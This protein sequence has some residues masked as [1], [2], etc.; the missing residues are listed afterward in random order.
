M[1][2][3]LDIEEGKEKPVINFLKQ[4]D[5]LTIK[6]IGKSVKKK[7]DSRITDTGDLPYFDTCPDWNMDV[8]EMRKKD[9]NRR[10]EGWL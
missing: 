2:Y 4:L 8:K 5:F 3:E 9:T 1:L 7:V 6:P 10:L